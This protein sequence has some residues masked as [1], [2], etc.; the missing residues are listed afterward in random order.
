MAVSKLNLVN[1]S[2]NR[3]NIDEVLTK[4]LH[5]DDFHVEPASKFID[6]VTGL[7]A[8]NPEPLYDELM[9]KLDQVKETYQ[10]ELQAVEVYEKN[11][12][13]LQ[14]KE[15]LMSLFEQIDQIEKV[16]QRL[17]KVVQENNEAIIQL[18]HL[19]QIGVSFDDL[20]S[21]KYLQIRLGK[22]PSK[23][24]AML[25]YYDSLPFIYREFHNDGKYVWCMYITTPANVLEIDNVFS[26]IY[27]ERIYLPNF[28]H[29]EPEIAIAEIEEESNNATEN[30]E[31]LRIRIL[32]LCKKY[33]QQLNQI[34]SI[35]LINQQLGVFQNYVFRVNDKYQL[36]GFV[37]KKSSDSL[38]QELEQIENVRV[39][40]RPEK[41]DGRLTPPTKLISN[42]FI[43]PFKMFVEM[44]GVPSY[45]DIDPTAFVAL[46]YTLLFGIMFG[47]V[48]QGL[49]LSIVG[50]IFYKLKGMELGAVGVRLGISSAFF[51]IIFGSVFGDEELLVPVFNA[52]AAENVMTL[53]MAAVGVGITLNIIS[54]IINVYIQLKRDQK[55]SAIFG[56][57]GI[58]GLVFYVAILLLIVNMLMPLPAFIGSIPYI[59]LGII[60]PLLLIFLEEPLERKFNQEEMFPDGVVG[61]ATQG[62]FELFEVCLSFATN[63]MSFLRVGGF[64]LSHGGMMLVVYTLANMVG[65]I[66]YWLILIF[67]N[68][69]VM[70]LEG[71]IV[72]IQVLRLEFYEMF[73]RYYE[74]NGVPFL[75]IKE[76]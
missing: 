64:V 40:I 35:S 53:L 11:I 7:Q 34:Y 9:E 33:Q 37:P 59:F 65:G 27:F 2:F 76:R 46:S 70:C 38:K 56:K 42:W 43:R 16:R 71:L 26:S 73:S 74:G 44:Y 47:D 3:D 41:S 12:N 22:I 62:F 32:D 61:Y 54:M 14:T 25:D 45:D 67:G 20:L 68:I 31:K 58:A 19:K 6:S 28:V 57:N 72:G 8:Y 30:I 15:E 60:L 69:F 39:S 13:L 5:I 55:V 66:G 75:S 63:T 51:G 52:M 36:V 1:I 29:G 10:L 49:V 17:Q 24:V 18:L 50:F 23:N 48:G 21:C 4:L